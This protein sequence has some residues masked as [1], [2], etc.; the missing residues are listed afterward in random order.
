MIACIL[1]AADPSEHFGSSSKALAEISGNTVIQGMVDTL[2][3]SSCEKIIVVL[4][5]HAHQVIS[6]IVIQDRISVVYNKDYFLGR[7]SSMQAGWREV[8][9]VYKGVLFLPVDYPLVKASTIDKLIEHFRQKNQEP[10]V[11]VA[12]YQNK[13]G[14]PQVFHQRLKSKALALPT[15]EALNSLFALYP[16]ETIEINDP[17][18]VKSFDTPQELKDILGKK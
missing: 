17:G 9:D 14:Y 1:L 7:T 12:A 15:D 11:L 8:E 6:S 16:P 3:Q 2:I 10:D 18:I 5:A 4:G 13:R